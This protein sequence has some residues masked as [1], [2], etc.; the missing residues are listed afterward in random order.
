MGAVPKTCRAC[1][2]VKRGEDFKIKLDYN[3]PV[4]T[5][6]DDE[7]LIRLTHTGI[8]MSDVHNLKADLGMPGDSECVGHEGAGNVVAFGAR[9]DGWAV[10]DRVG[11]KPCM[12]ACRNCELCNEG[13]DGMCMNA[14]RAAYHENGSYAQYLVTPASYATR[15]P[16]ELSDEL[17][18]PLLCSG[19]TTFRAVNQSTA[20]IGQ[21][22]IITGAG[23]GVGSIGIRVIGIDTSE[24]KRVL[25]LQT[26]GCEAFI[27]FAT[28]SDIPK[29]VMRITGRGAHASII[30]GG[31]PGAYANWWENL[32]TGGTMVVVGL[33]PR[34]TTIAGADPIVM[35]LKSLRI[36]A[37]FVGSFQE[38]YM[39]LEI[40]AA[41]KVKPAITIF[42]FAEFVE[43]VDL[44]RFGKLPGRA[45]IRFDD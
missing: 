21:W 23:G 29:E 5:P 7:L 38:T 39:A 16:Q 3:Y 28:C 43:A 34:G 33:P 20:R 42:P 27:D 37:T 12:Y 30:T 11:V 2:V 14:R 13:F 26:L 40:A 45:V 18:A 1:V 22:L 4:P 44:V 24:A 25:C 32:R 36:Q 10:G 9:V 17:A 8:C 35:V 6:K 15:I 31:T 41:G 19:A